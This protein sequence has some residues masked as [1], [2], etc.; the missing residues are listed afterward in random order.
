MLRKK[1]API[2]YKIL[3]MEVNMFALTEKDNWHFRQEVACKQVLH[4]RL[5]NATHLHWVN[6]ANS[7]FIINNALAGANELHCWCY[8]KC[9]WKWENNL[10]GSTRCLAPPSNISQ[11]VI[12]FLILGTGVLGCWT[13][14][15]TVCGLLC[16]CVDNATKLW[17]RILNSIYECELL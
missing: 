3:Y 8:V 7:C 13:V 16:H 2:G 6:S 4:H 15:N 10:I 11:P 5:T 9:I 12:D 14:R 17:I 1:R